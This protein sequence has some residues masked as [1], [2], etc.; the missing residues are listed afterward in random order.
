MDFLK[1]KCFIHFQVMKFHE[2][3]LKNQKKEYFAIFDSELTLGNHNLGRDFLL[4]ASHASLRNENGRIVIR[5]LSSHFGT[6]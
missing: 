4:S 6:S 5:D 1:D 3:V 2:G